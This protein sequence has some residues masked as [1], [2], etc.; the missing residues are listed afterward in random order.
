M[1]LMHI[2]SD[3]AQINLIIH[4]EY[5]VR[6][7]FQFSLIDSVNICILVRNY[8]GWKLSHLWLSFQSVYII[9]SPIEM[10]DGVR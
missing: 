9:H 3:N 2:V 4:F 6:L 5:Q 7:V 8:N 10:D 1:Q